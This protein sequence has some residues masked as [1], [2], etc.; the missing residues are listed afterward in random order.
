VGKLPLAIAYAQYLNCLNPLESE[1]CG[2]CTSCVKYNHLTHPDLHFV[3]P[4]IKKDKK[5]VCDDYIK[6]W[7]AFLLILV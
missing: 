3:F 7:R 2:E 4:I 6:D 5:E 1:S